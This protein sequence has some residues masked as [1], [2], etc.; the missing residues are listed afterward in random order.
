MKEFYDLIDKI[1]EELNS[2]EF[3]NTV[4]FGNIMDVDLSKQ[5]IFPLS[6][7]NIQDAVFGDHTITF[8]IQVIAMDLVDE[9]KEDKFDTDSIPYQGLDN[10]HDVLNTQLAVINRLQSKLRRGDLNDDN[11]V[12]DTDATAT[13][14]ED[15]FENLMTGWAL[16]L[17]ISIPNNV[18]TVC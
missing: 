9:S 7:I 16:T 14:F 17:S 18:V 10:K 3:V 13:M 4:T 2:S 5:S 12:L 6:H 11:Y 8:S 1:Y 15:R